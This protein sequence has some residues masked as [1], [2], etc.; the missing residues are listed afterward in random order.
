MSIPVFISFKP[1]FAIFRN[2]IGTLSVEFSKCSF[3]S[4]FPLFQI[5]LE[6]SSIQRQSLWLHKSNSLIKVERRKKAPIASDNP[7]SQVLHLW[8]RDRISLFCGHLTAPKLSPCLIHRILSTRVSLSPSP[9]L[10]R[11]LWWKHLYLII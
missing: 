5:Y 8:N 2:I 11:C 10:Y 7:R 6:I 1:N 9:F 4:L 3:F